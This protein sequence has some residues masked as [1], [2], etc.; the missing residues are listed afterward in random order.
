M[1]RIVHDGKVYNWSRI[2]PNN[3]GHWMHRNCITHL[4]L[5]SELT[6]EARSQGI[7]EPHNFSRLPPKPKKE[8]AIRVQG[9][10]RTGTRRSKTAV[11][12]RLG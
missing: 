3:E 1:I 6:Q 12:I 8:K 9:K 11:R 2:G 10:R 7:E 5:D 4:V